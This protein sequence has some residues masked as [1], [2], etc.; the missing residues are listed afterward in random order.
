[1]DDKG[2]TRGKMILDGFEDLTA[3]AAEEARSALS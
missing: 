1:M 2:P 3:E